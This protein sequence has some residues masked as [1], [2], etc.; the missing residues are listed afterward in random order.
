MHQDDA[1]MHV[2]SH[3]RFPGGLYSENKARFPLGDFFFARREAKTRICYRGWLTLVGEKNLREQVGT[4]L[5]F[6][7]S[8]EQ[9]RQVENGLKKAKQKVCHSRKFLTSNNIQI[10]IDL[11]SVCE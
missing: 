7:C 1:V 2:S 3:R 8:H 11:N 5:T 4:V 10:I 6:F 9:I